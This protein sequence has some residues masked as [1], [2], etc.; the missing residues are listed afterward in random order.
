MIAEEQWCRAGA[1]PAAIE[2]DVV[3]PNGQ[4]SFDIPFDVLRWPGVVQTQSPD[5]DTLGKAVLELLDPWDVGDGWR[6]RD[7][8]RRYME[9]DPSYRDENFWVA[10]DAGRLVS[11][12]QVFPR[13]LLQCP[14]KVSELQLRQAF[15]CL[16]ILRILL[17]PTLKHA[18]QLL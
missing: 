6:G 9:L 1:S 11:C 4:R 3:N 10:D 5:V 8:F 14:L 16:L 18:A 12:V 7:F 17:V 2:D 13:R 15:S